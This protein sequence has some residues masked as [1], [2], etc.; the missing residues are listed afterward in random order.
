M[1]IFALIWRLLPRFKWYS[2]M[3]WPFYFIG[4]VAFFAAIWFG[5]PMTGIALFGTVW[6]RLTV[7]G[8]I[9]GIFLLV[10]FIKWRRRVKK[11]A[12]LEAVLIATKSQ[13][14][15]GA[16]KQLIPLMSASPC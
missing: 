3:R 6:F 13:H 15:A 9:V 14:T 1:N 8:V 4:F 5:G 16:V 2:W 7:I 10:W 11:A 12:A